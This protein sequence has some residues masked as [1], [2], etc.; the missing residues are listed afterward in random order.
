MTTSDVTTLTDRRPRAALDLRVMAQLILLALTAASWAVPAAE[1]E[2]D[3]RSLHESLLILDTHLDAPVHFGRPGWS[4]LDRHSMETD[5][6]QIDYPR[7]IDGGLDGGFWVIYTSQGPLTSAGYAAA[8]DHALMR[9]VQIRAMVDRASSVF[10]LALRANDAARIVTS[11]KRVVYQSI[12]NSYPLGTDL[13]LL[14]TFHDL[15]VRL[16]G[17]V[18]Y[19]NN[20]FADSSTD[21]KAKWGGLSPLGKQLIDEANRLGMVLDA[22]HASDA[23]F[24]QMLERS[25]TPIVLSHSGL[26]AIFD[27]PRNLDD[28]RLKKLAASGGVIQV[29]AVSEFLVNTPVIA[30]R[31]AAFAERGRNLAH[32]NAADAASMARRM[33]DLD[34]QYQVPLATFDDFIQGLLHA[35]D[36]AGVDHVGIGMDWDGGAGLVGFEDVTALPKVSARLRQAGYSREDLGKIMGGNVLRVL[37]QAEIYAEKRSGDAAR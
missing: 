33:R 35:I 36:V 19:S 22:S 28:A 18:H 6:S 23:T 17:P 37:R 4:I 5:L 10:E 14:K 13:T 15:G 20:Q 34:R 27:H 7:M 2:S 12:E 8:R 26:K 25:K 11:G 9:A 21:A 24:D 29:M 1:A 30:E 16:V 3:E 31:E 32:Y